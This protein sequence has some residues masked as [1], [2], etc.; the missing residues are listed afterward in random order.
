MEN[1][2]QSKLADAVSGRPLPIII[3]NDKSGE[4]RKFMIYQPT[5]AMLIETSKILSEIGLNE[6]ENLF[7]GKDIFTFISVNGE[8]ILKVISIILDRNVDYSKETFDYLKENLTPG[9][10]YD[11]LA[12]ITLRIGVRDFQKSIVELIPMSLMNQMEI[13]ALTEKNLNLSSS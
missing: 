9:E 8:K 11:L 5:F 4:E 1:K 3:K 6:I 12:N 7:R 10:C 13:I 2:I